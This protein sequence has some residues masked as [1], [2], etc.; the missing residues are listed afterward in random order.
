M[1]ITRGS[2]VNSADDRNHL[3][4]VTPLPVSDGLLGKGSVYAHTKIRLHWY[5]LGGCSSAPILIIISSSYL[6]GLF[7]EECGPE[8]GEGQQCREHKVIRAPFCRGVHGGSGVMLIHVPCE[9]H[10]L[11]FQPSFVLGE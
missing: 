9:Q 3:L 1:P 7:L 4:F 10:A 8:R 11:I 2:H 5:S 6:T